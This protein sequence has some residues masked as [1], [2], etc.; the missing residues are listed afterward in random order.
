MSGE[1]SPRTAR[2]YATLGGLLARIGQLDEAMGLLDGAAS[3]LMSTEGPH[4]ATTQNVVEASLGL[5]ATKVEQLVASKDKA[6]ASVLLTH[7]L[8]TGGRVLGFNHAAILA[9]RKIASDHRITI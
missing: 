1:S 7:G 9:L 3:L 8:T 2:R 6:T 5:I 4:H